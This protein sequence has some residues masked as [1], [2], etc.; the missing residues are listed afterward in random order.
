LVIEEV[1]CIRMFA[2]HSITN[3]K[4]SIFNFQYI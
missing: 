2:A 4:F 3:N 1:P